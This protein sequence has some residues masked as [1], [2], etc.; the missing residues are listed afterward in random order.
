MDGKNQ[1]MD[2][3]IPWSHDGHCDDKFRG[4]FF[5]LIP[6]NIVYL[7]Q[8]LIESISLTLNKTFTLYE[9][10]SISS[11]IEI[12]TFVYVAWSSKRHI[13]LS[14]WIIYKIHTSNPIINEY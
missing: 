7:R 1:W 14:C 12:D 11:K 3:V 13:K 6:C 10:K 2:T 5:W 4:T 8:F 9:N